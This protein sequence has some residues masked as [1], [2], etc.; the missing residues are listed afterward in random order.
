MQ[1]LLP[2]LA[3]P[4]ICNAEDDQGPLHHSL[5]EDRRVGD[6][7]LEPG[8]AFEQGTLPSDRLVRRGVGANRSAEK[9][10]QND[11]TQ[12]SPTARSDGPE[13]TSLGGHA[14][15]SWRA[16][17]VRA[18]RRLGELREDPRPRLPFHRERGERPPPALRREEGDCKPRKSA[19]P[20][21]DHSNTPA[22]AQRFRSDLCSNQI[23]PNTS[24]VRT[25]GAVLGARTI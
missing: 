4:L 9:I 8:Q 14:G 19:T 21:T 23:S 24:N 13:A 11:R 1:P 16:R 17:Q 6:V 15:P 25:Q 12:A 18:V 5:A 10:G 3:L 2:V 22:S 7:R 20:R